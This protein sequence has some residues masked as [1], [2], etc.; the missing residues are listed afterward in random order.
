MATTTK[1]Q[2]TITKFQQETY[3]LIWIEAF[4]V[5]RKSQYFHLLPL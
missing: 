2:W 3:L 1:N 5:F 4:L